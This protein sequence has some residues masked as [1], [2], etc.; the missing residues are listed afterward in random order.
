[1]AAVGC[2]GDSE[3]SAFIDSEGQV[4]PVHL[5]NRSQF[6]VRE[7]TI[8]PP[9]SVDAG[10]TQVLGELPIDEEVQIEAFVSGSSVAFLRDR[11]AGGDPIQIETDQP[12]FVNAAG[13]TLLLF[14]D[15]FR[16]LGPDHPD[17][18]FNATEP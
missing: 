16:L 2:A 13:F 8:S 3:G 5:W 15:A 6:D 14:D 4:H 9:P 7:I 10:L 12:V 17:N 1:M 18:P 11:V